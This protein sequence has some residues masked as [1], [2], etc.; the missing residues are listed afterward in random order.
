MHQGVALALETRP[1]VP[2]RSAA[3]TPQGDWGCRVPYT[4][5]V[6]GVRLFKPFS[7]LLSTSVFVSFLFLELIELGTGLSGALL[8]PAQG[9][10]GQEAKAARSGPAGTKEPPSPFGD[11]RASSYPQPSL[12]QGHSW[13]GSG[14]SA[15]LGTSVLARVALRQGVGVGGSEPTSQSRADACFLDRRRRQWGTPDWHSFLFP[16]GKS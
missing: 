16:L 11:P 5:C 3:L 13:A 2:A 10:A 9:C 14:Q 6:P 1:P 15:R 12:H 7:L 4:E 8:P